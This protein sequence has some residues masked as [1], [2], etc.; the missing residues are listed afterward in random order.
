MV[1]LLAGALVALVAPLASATQPDGAATPAPPAGASSPPPETRRR[2]V[3]AAIGDSLTDTRVGGGRYMSY[4]AEKCPKS[5]FDAYGVGGQQ[6]RHMRWRFTQDLFG[7]GLRG[8]PPK[9]AYTDVIVLGG[10]NDLSG[11]TVD[12]A[13]LAKTREQL[14]W[15]YRTGHERGLRVIALTVP[16]WG[17]WRRAHDRRVTE[18]INGWILG[19]QA[20]GE[21]D[22]AIDIHPLLTCGDDE[23]LCARFRMTPRDTIHWSPAGHETVASAVQRAAF[24]DCE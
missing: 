10:V 12:E 14:S 13:R 19:R 3:V 2:H 1:L 15:M 23:Q 24:S 20:A 5:R 21:V 16:P 11:G 7:D 22:V 9:P 4:L 8:A 17:G 6:T 18:E